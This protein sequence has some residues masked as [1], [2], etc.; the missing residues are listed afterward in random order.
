MSQQPL[1]LSVTIA[2]LSHLYGGDLAGVVET[3]QLADEHG[4]DQ[5]VVADHVV[6]GPNLEAYPYGRFPLP[7]EEPWPDPLV[8]L[9]AMAGA[10]RHVRLGTGILITPLRPAVLLAKQLATLDVLSHGRIDAGVGTGWQREEYDASGIAWEDRWQL[11]EDGLRACRA[12]W[13][14]APASFSSATVSFDEIWSLPRPVQE[15]GVPFWFGVKLTRKNLARIA[16]LGAGWMPMDSRPE[17]LRLGIAKLRAAFDEAGR[18]FD[19]FRV[20]AHPEV[21]LRADKSVDL[22]ATLAGSSAL[23]ELGVTDLSFGLPRFARSRDEIP[24]FFERLGSWKKSG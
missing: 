6:I 4:I 16:E 9:A 7:P 5:L 22:E 11:L 12:L 3:A 1:A 18:C 17:N 20:R 21:V 19:G 15:G 13:A 23:A 2:G 14:E 8:L 10:T 24:S